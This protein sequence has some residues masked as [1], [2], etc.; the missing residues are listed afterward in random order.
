MRLS[1]TAAKKRI[2]ELSK[3]IRYHTTLYHEKDAPE[4]SDEAYD[5]LVRE[6]QILEEKYPVLAKKHS[7]TN[8]VGGATDAAFKKITHRVRQW[9]FDN[10]FS[11]QELRAWEERLLRVLLKEGVAQTKISYVA[12]HKI[13]GLKVIL[14]YDR[15]VLVRATTRGDGAV[16]EDIT[17]TARTITD[18]PE[19]LTEPVTLIVV[20]EAWL[21]MDAFLRINAE[22]VKQGEPLFAN[23]RNAAAGSLRQLDAEVTRSRKLSFFAYDIDYIDASTLRNRVPETQNDELAL[24]KKLGC[25][26]NPHSEYCGDIDAVIRYYDTWTPK[27]NA[28]EYGMDGVVVKVN[29]IVLQQVAGYTAKAPRFGIAYKFPSEEATTVV[30]DIQLQVGRTGVLTPVAHLRP[31]LI[32]GSTVSRATLH[33]EDQIARLDVR[34]GDTIILQKAGDV[35]PEILRVVV[36]LRPKKSRPYV[37][38]THVMECGGDGRIERV[39]GMSAYRCVAKDSATQ[40]RRRLYYFVSKHGLNIDGVGPRIIDL[41]LEHALINTYADLFTLTTGDLIGLPSFKEKAAEN[42]IRAIDAVRVCPL[43]RFLTALGIQHVGEETARILTKE[44]TTIE[45]LRAAHEAELARV[46]GVGDV[47][48]HS[49]VSWMRES[50]HRHVL[51]ALCE[52]ITFVPEVGTTGGKLSGCSFVFTGTLPT[53][54]R[55]E[56]E[57]MVRT[58]G[59]HVTS[60]VSKSTSYV[61]VGS[62]PGSKADRARALAVPVLTEEDFLALIRA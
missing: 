38:P 6:L 43:S 55:S 45:S 40:H 41:L 22:R 37:F 49:L 20:G 5:S 62:D 53:L 19:K 48:A 8:T 56:G 28:M 50:A 54:S 39:P 60:A 10:V 44:F 42:V 17:H 46:H 1:Q 34:I 13:D 7:P 11:H 30:E 23:P 18:I 24:L 52:H 33:N 59:G 61:V 26:V 32:A 14:E 29:E 21:S 35:I 12:E 4:I 3:L 16:G 57:E 51:D 15:G 9:S 31:V 2:V 36:A 25:S 58:H 27:K 47:V